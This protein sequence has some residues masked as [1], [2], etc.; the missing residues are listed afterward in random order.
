MRPLFDLFDSN[1]FASPKRRP[2][3]ASTR[4]VRALRAGH[5]PCSER[6]AR[7]ARR[8][9]RAPRRPC[10]RWGLPGRGRRRVA[11]NEVVEAVGS[12]GGF[13][14]MVAEVFQSFLVPFLCGKILWQMFTWKSQTCV[15]INGL[16]STNESNMFL[17]VWFHQCFCSPSCFFP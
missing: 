17:P 2:R 1:F 10:C 12:F 13:F 15:S 7:G 4:Q 9:T 8:G 5:L 11:S 3:V 16:E 14:S 6:L